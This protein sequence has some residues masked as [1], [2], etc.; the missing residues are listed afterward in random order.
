MPV[1]EHESQDCKKVFT[2]VLTLRERDDG[3]AA[4]PGCGSK[5]V[6]Q[7]ISTFIAKTDSKT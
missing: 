1:Y 3:E 7:L 6:R 2:V 4:C 5:K